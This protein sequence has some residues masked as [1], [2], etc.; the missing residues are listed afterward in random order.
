MKDKKC[1]APIKG[2]AG[3]KS[4]MY[5]FITEGNHKS[6]KVKGIIKNVVNDKLKYEYN[7]LSS[8]VNKIY[9]YVYIDR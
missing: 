6:K 8:Y 9:I 4:K 5:T 1:A 2:F 7:N 3:L